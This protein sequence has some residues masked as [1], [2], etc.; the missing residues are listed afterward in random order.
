MAE[1]RSPLCFVSDQINAKFHLMIGFM[2][3]LAIKSIP[4]KKWAGFDGKP[5]DIN[6]CTSSSST[7]RNRLV[8]DTL[9]S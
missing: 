2:E 4:G 8:A 1:N 6:N 3:A 7:E 9:P 5:D